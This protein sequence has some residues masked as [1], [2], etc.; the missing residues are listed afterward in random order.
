MIKAMPNGCN[1]LPSI[2]LRKNNGAKD[3]IMMNVAI[4]IELRISKEAS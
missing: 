4:T 3:R 2:P 1:N